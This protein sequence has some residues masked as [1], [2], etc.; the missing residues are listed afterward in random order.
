VK[1]PKLERCDL[2]LSGEI[3]S[4]LSGPRAVLDVVTEK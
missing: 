1:H 2:L 3:R 4:Y